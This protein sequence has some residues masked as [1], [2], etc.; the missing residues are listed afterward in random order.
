MK[1]GVKHIFIAIGLYPAAE[2]RALQGADGQRPLGYVAS[3][4]PAGF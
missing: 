3:R 2:I 4:N 1:T